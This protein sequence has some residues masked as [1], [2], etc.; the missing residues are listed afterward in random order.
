MNSVH[1]VAHMQAVKL[2]SVVRNVLEQCL[3]HMLPGFWLNAQQE[4]TC[5]SN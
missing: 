4:S 3:G 5:G 1:L 2:A